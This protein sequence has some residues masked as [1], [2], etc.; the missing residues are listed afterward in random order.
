MVR[1]ILPWF[2]LTFLLHLHKIIWNKGNKIIQNIPIE[3]NQNYDAYNDLPMSLYKI[4]IIIIIIIIMRQAHNKK[5]VGK[6]TA[7][8]RIGPLQGGRIESTC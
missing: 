3:G 8:H 1:V 4:I 2:P 5:T 7:N 6:F